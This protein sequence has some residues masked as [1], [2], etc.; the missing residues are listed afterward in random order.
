MNLNNSYYE[1]DHKDQNNIARLKHLLV[2]PQCKGQLSFLINVIRCKSCD[3]G[4]VQVSDNWFNLISHTPLD[5][6]H[7]LWE[8]RQKSMEEW[9]KDLVSS[10]EDAKNCFTSDYAPYA[11][12]L[13]KLSGVILDIGGGVGI[14]RNYLSNITEY[15]VIDPSIDWLKINWTSLI[16]TFPCLEKTPS[17]VRGIGESLPF[18]SETFDVVLSFWS[19]NHT[20]NPEQVFYEAARVLKPGGKFLIVLEDMLP[21][22]YD[23]IDFN[24]PAKDIFNSYFDSLALLNEKNPRFKLFLKYLK[25]ENWPLQSDHIFIKETDILNWSSLNFEVSWRAWIKQFLTFEFIKIA[26]TSHK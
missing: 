22:W 12:Y 4:F 25:S 5:N 9:Y 16:E 6:E 26:P 11:E 10:P 23:F 1:S 18:T 15:I 2:C 19:M 24:F 17:F 20:N 7:S 3:L 21:Q 8:E 14:V 13:N